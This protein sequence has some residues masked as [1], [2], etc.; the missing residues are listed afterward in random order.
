ME[1]PPDYEGFCVGSLE[2]SNQ[3]EDFSAT[4]S[5]VKKHNDAG[6]KGVGPAKLNWMNSTGKRSS[7][8]DVYGGVGL[9][10]V[11]TFFGV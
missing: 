5:E 2:S 1:P 6:S 7:T 10:I 11:T 4:F 9:R 8:H 3:F